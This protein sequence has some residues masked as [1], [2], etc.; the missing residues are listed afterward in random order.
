MNSNQLQEEIP[1]HSLTEATASNFM[2]HY[3]KIWAES[4]KQKQ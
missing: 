4:E 3:L 2:I 1:H